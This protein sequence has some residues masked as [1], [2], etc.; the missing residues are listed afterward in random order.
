M[1][2]A[3]DVVIAGAGVTGLSTALHLARRKAGRIIVLDKGPVGDGS[4][5]RA[6]GIITGHLWTEVGIQVRRR[7]L[8]LYRELSE[9]LEGYRFQQ[10]GCLNLFSAAEWPERDKLLPLYDRLGIPYQVLD[11]AKITRLW[12]GLHPRTDETGLF[13]PLGGYSEPAEY[14]PAL[15][16]R[17]TELG[18]EIREH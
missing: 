18:V 2:Q 13:D 9:E 4:S 10:P 1:K 15:R 6:A 8:Q 11:A 5:S 3:A 12:P 14:V 17:A 7:C 16:R